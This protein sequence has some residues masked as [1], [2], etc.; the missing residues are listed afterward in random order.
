M[1]QYN[2]FSGLGL[3]VGLTSVS[4]RRRGELILKVKSA[5]SDFRYVLFLR[6]TVDV[7]VLYQR[8]EISRGVVVGFLAL[9]ENGRTDRKRPKLETGIIS[10]FR[11]PYGER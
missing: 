11:I 9:G 1:G 8:V 7:V 3:L 2:N 10:S 4:M 6:S 5:V